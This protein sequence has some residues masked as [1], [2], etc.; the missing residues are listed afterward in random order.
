MNG[1]E[2]LRNRVERLEQQVGAGPRSGRPFLPMWGY[3]YKSSVKILG[4]P[5]LHVA[6]GVDP[7]T[8]RLLVARGVIAV[9]N[10]AFGVLA[11]GGVAFGVL[12]LGGL[13]FGV[14]ALAGLAVAVYAALGG[15]AIAGWYAFG[16]LAVA[17]Y[18]AVGGMAVSWNYAFGGF[19]I[20][21]YPYG[22]NY[23][24]PQALE[25]LRRTFP[26]WKW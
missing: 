3:E 22:S 15:V 17:G 4:L 12:A 16:G 19:A 7:N 9:G 13:A 23:Q 14:L 26:G 2:E 10:V 1:D 8:G 5:L 11:I 20:G 24:D 18:V 21:K 25:F 6:S